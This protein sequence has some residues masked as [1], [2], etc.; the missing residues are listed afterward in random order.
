MTWA[1]ILSD[2]AASGISALPDQ[3]IHRAALAL[4]GWNSIS[5]KNE[6]H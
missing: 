6:E 5:L 4:K 2:K 3:F 1:A